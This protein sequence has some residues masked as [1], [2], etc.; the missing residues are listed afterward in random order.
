MNMKLAAYFRLRNLHANYTG[1]EL[2]VQV[3]MERYEVK[4]DSDKISRTKKL[5]NSMMC[6]WERDLMTEVKVTKYA[7]NILLSLTE[8]IYMDLSSFVFALNLV[9]GIYKLAWFEGD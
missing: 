6:T 4:R 5:N 9:D 7:G 1:K 8:T 2:S 3:V